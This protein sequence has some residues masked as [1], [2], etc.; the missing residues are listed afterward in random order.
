MK[1][2]PIR[3]IGYLALCSAKHHDDSIHRIDLGSKRYKQLGVRERF[4]DEKPYRV[5]KRCI[6]SVVRRDSL[7]RQSSMTRS[8][9]GTANVR[10]IAGWRN[11]DKHHTDKALHRSKGN[12]KSLLLALT[13]LYKLAR[14]AAA[15]KRWKDNSE[16]CACHDDLALRLLRGYGSVRL[17]KAWLNSKAVYLSRKFKKS[18]GRTE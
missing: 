18:I 15:E 17:P 2:L 6:A 5:C 9:F 1:R 7:E 16:L 3:H 8:F 11:R 4:K 12:K 10:T 13:W 14:K